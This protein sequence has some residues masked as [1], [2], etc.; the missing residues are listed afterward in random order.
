MTDNEFPRPNVMP[1]HRRGHLCNWPACQ[2]RG[3]YA[4]SPPQDCDGRPG[5]DA[6]SAAL[7]QDARTMTGN[8]FPRLDINTE[9]LRKEVERLLKVAKKDKASMGAVNWGDLGIAIY[10]PN[11]DRPY[12]VVVIKGA[13]PYC[14]LQKFLHENLDQAKFPKVYFECEW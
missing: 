12:C 10:P 13:A 7:D 5:A 14:H 4:L 11:G 2:P 8:E 3:V 6:Y 1:C 9:K